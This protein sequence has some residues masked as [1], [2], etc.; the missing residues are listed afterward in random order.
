MAGGV[1]EAPVPC[2]RCAASVTIEQPR[3]T[4]LG[5]RTFRCPACRRVCNERPGTLFNHLPYPTGLVLLVVLW[6]RRYKLRLRDLAG[7]LLERGFAFSHE[8]VRGWEARFAAL[9]TARLRATRR[10]QTGVRWH[11]DEPSIR[12]DGRRCH[13]ARALDRA[14]H[15][16]EAPR[17]AQRARD[18]APRLFAPAQVTTEGRDA[19]PRAG[20]ETPGAG[21]VH[22]TSRYKNDRIEQGHRA[23]KQRSYPIRGFGACASAARLCVGFA[24]QHQYSRARIRSGERVTSME[25]RRRFPGGR[26]AVMAALAAA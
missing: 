14:G 21:A 8:A 23:I 12:A 5:Y 4:A 13:L 6:R 24:A 25:R 7:L 20:R 3:R 10:G 15:L 19:Y 16:V 2:P 11:A 18:A 17:R 9:L 26:A 22:R 1:Q